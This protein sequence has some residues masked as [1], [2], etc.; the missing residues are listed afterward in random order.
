MLQRQC[1]AI[2][3]VEQYVMHV[4]KKTMF[5]HC[6]CCAACNACYKEDNVLPS[7]LLCSMECMLQR[8]QCS[9]IVTVV[10]H[11]MHV[12]KKTMFSHCH[13]CAACNAC[14][15]E[16]NVLP[17]SLLCSM[18]CMLQRRQCS[19]IV[20]VVQHG[21]HVTKKTM[22]CHCHCCA[23]WNACYKEDNVLPLS[24]LCSM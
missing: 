5:C 9:A 8:R 2:V 22:F 17:L 1:S 20:T 3:T 12:T 14:Y 23:A 13:C 4:T 11:V 24:L 19:A 6:H 16:D 18:E 21:M 15:K 10:Q 7:S